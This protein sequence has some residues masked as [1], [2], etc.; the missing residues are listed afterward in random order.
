MMIQWTAESV[1][2]LVV[3]LPLM[4]GYVCRARKL[5]VWT[6][7]TLPNLFHL[8]GGLQVLGTVIAGLMTGEVGLGWLGLCMCATW[9]AWSYVTW[10]EK[11]PHYVTRPAPLD[12]AP[13]GRVWSEP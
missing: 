7:R 12:E 5:S 4:C 1:A 10:R 13:R 9:L 6:T 3:G 2:A 8:L 11:V